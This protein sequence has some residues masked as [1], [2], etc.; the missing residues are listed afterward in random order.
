MERVF[1]SIQQVLFA[2]CASLGVA[3]VVVGCQHSCSSGNCQG[4]GANLHVDNCSDIPQGAIPLPIGTYT[5][6]LFD[7]QAVKAE[8]DDFVVYYNEWVDNQAILGPYGR[9]H[10]AQ[11]I[12]RLPSVPFPVIVQPEPERFMLNGLRQQNMIEAL[13]LAGIP[14]AARRVFVGRGA[15]EGLFGEE[16]ERIYPSLVN[17]SGGFGGG[18][19][20][21]AGA[22]GF[23][24]AGFAGATGYAGGGIAG[25]A[26]LSGG[27]F[28][29]FGGGNFSGIR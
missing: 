1:R 24:G 6:A 9:E 14:D 17:G 15:A 28:G 4:A 3:A 22:A 29:A 2:L 5:H 8:A 16:A 20:G 10:L 12:A 19:A 11:M 27:G 26:G 21:N 7:R 23:A 25:G 13:T 18:G